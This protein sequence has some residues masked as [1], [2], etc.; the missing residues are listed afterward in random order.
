MSP[1]RMSKIES[2]LR[3]VLLFV[4]AFNLHD[5]A[6]MA[7]LFSSDCIFDE[8]GPGPGGTV[9]RGIADISRHIVDVF[10]QSPDICITVE[11]ISG[12]GIRSVLRYKY[13]RINLLGNEG[14]LRGMDLF[15]LKDGLI[16]ERCS[17][18]K[19]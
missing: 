1:V 18:I 3:V 15:Q 8:S 17:Y 5:L 9:Y 19:S 12:L 6:S 7:Q 2:G 13:E 10:H 4:E 11:D 16:C 14:Y